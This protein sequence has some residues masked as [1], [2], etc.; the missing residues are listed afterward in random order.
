MQLVVAQWVSEQCAEALERYG[1]KWQASTVHLVQAER[2]K[3]ELL[4]E[5]LRLSLSPPPNDHTRHPSRTGEGEDAGE[6]FQVSRAHGSAETQGQYGAPISTIT[7]PLSMKHL[8]ADGLHGLRSAHRA[9]HAI[10]QQ[11]TSTRSGVAQPKENEH[12]KSDE[13]HQVHTIRGS[14]HWRRKGTVTHSS[15]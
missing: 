1:E 15:T 3:Y 9:Q 2:E 12:T 14:K 8:T 13:Q 4:L 11:V 5:E 6:R 7:V 10:R